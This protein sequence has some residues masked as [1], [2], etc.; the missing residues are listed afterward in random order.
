[1]DWI[2]FAAETVI[3]KIS[4]KIAKKVYSRRYSSGGHLPARYLEKEFWKEISYGQTE[5][6]ECACDVDGRAFSCS[7]A[8]QL[9]IG[10]WNLERS[11]LHLSASLIIGYYIYAY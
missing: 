3:L 9:R 4:R 8:Y 5:S 1:M 7:P 11:V 2:A 10:K 6:V